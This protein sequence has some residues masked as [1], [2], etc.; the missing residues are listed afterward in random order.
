MEEGATHGITSLSGKVHTLA[1]WRTAACMCLR[2]MIDR[3]KGV[4]LYRIVGDET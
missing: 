4:I 1:L 2:G 3:G